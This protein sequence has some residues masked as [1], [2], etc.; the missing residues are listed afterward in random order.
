MLSSVQYILIKFDSASSAEVSSSAEVYEAEIITDHEK[1]GRTEDHVYVRLSE[2]CVRQN[3]LVEQLGNEVRGDLLRG[4]LGYPRKF[5]PFL[6]NV[7]CS[8]FLWVR[9]M[10]VKVYVFGK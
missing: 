3:K 8:N 1:D 2:Q 5:G 9:V 6:T 4:S 10:S 7:L